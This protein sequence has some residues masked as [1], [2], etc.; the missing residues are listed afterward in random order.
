MAAKFHSR[1]HRLR[2]WK[3]DLNYLLSPSS[4]PNALARRGTNR[5]SQN[6]STSASGSSHGR[7]ANPSKS[8]STHHHNDKSKKEKPSSSQKST[9]ATR[10]HVCHQCDKPFY[11]QEQLKRHV[12][13]VHENWRPFKCLF[14]EVTFGT[15]QNLHVHFTTR[16]HRH[17]FE[18]LE[19]SNPKLA[20]ELTFKQCHLEKSWRSPTASLYSFMKYI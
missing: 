9:V 8:S 11:K 15:K 20:K 16:K 4:K 6:H 19:A 13:L 17:R 12:R 10:P 1:T 5:S 14:C 7:R 3:M 18:S 2:L